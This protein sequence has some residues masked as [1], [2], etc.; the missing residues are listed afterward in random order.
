M[1]K[2]LAVILVLVVA[3]GLYQMWGVDARIEAA[4][5]ATN[6]ALLLVS[7]E[8]TKNVELRAIVEP[9]IKQLQ[10]DNFKLNEANQ[11][12]DLQIGTERRRRIIAQNQADDLRKKQQEEQEDVLSSGNQELVTK[13][14]RMIAQA[15]PQVTGE[16]YAVYDDKDFVG[17]RS[18][19]DA[20]GLSLTEALSSRMILV[21]QADENDT[22]TNELQLTTEQKDN[23]DK[24]LS[25][26]QEAHR[27]T[28]DLLVSER[29]ITGTNETAIAALSEERD[30][31]KSKLEFNWLAPKCGIGGFTGLGYEGPTLGI[32]IFCG[33]VLN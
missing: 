10:E 15:Y 1:I 21:S 18:T 2:V 9:K 11:Q 17:N 33:W 28:N 25:N 23:L 22:L 29:A 16:T 5:D 4:E 27:S 12:K 26:E 14:L 13:T 3:F 32:G 30:A 24:A 8:K 7:Q 31:Y 19:A 6:E 20:F